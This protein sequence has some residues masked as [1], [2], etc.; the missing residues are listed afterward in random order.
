M[1]IVM[2]PIMFT[3]VVPAPK[4]AGSAQSPESHVTPRAAFVARRHGRQPH[5]RDVV[6]GVEHAA[7]ASPLV[8]EAT[9]RNALAEAAPALMG[10]ASNS[11]SNAMYSQRSG[12]FRRDQAQANPV[13]EGVVDLPNELTAGGA[14]DLFVYNLP[15]LTLGKGDRMAVPILSTEVPGTEGRERR[16]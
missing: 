16:R 7:K 4:P 9:L 10:N 12:E 3:N 13:A 2:P 15:K 14:Q 11:L 1:L 5:G 8:L 6:D